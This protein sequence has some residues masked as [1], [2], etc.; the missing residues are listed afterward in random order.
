MG[1]DVVDFLYQGRYNEGTYLILPFALSGI[2][3]LFYS[4]PSSVIGGRLPRPALKQFMWFNLGAVVLHIALDVIM[5]RAMGLLG[6]A[7]ATAIA[8]GLRLAGGYVI[9][10]RHRSHLAEPTGERN[11]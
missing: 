4:V 3:K 5:I 2:A 11:A 6:A 1:R 8:W 7:I 9:I 10:A